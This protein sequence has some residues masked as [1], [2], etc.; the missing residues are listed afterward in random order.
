MSY[1][2]SGQYEVTFHVLHKILDCRLVTSVFAEGM[3]SIPLTTEVRPARL[4]AGSRRELWE[5]WESRVTAHGN[6]KKGLLGPSR[7]AVA[8]TG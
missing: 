6:L 7:G 4:V 1:V 5:L 3:G 8:G 2:R